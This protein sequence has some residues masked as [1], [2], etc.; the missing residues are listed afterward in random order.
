LQRPGKTVTSALAIICDTNGD[1]VTDLTIPLTAVTPIN[2]NLV[3]G[4]VAAVSAAQL[5]GT[6]F[7]LTCCGGVAAVTLTTSFT[8]GDNNIFGLFSRTAT[9]FI[10]LGVRAPVV[11]SVTP[12]RGNCGICQDLLISGACF[13]LPSAAVG[14]GSTTNVTSVFAVDA[15]NPATVIQATTFTVLNPNLVDA[16]F[17]FGS[18]NAGKRFLIF[19]SGPNG[20]SQNLTTLPAGANCPAGFTGNQQGVQVTFTCDTQGNPVCTPGTPGCPIIPTPAV[21]TNC[22]LDRT[23]AGAFV[24]TITGDKIKA[25]ALV[26]LSGQ[27]PKSVKFKSLNSAG[28]FTRVTAK[29]RVCGNI[30]GLIV[31][32]NPPIAGVN[33]PPSVPFNCTQ[34]CPNL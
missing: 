14:A 25:G 12:S 6:G 17:C 34:R 30:P 23:A 29:G 27:T 28:D 16:L 20:T 5:P 1:G 19:V 32:T 9:C 3:R 18:A 8:P 26:T 15:A 24:L 31:I 4:T 21:V 22:Q 10:D 11:I 13:V 33:A 2:K 7:P